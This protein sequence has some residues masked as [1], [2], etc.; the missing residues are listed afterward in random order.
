[1]GSL[2]YKKS[3]DVVR[4]VPKDLWSIPI[5]DINMNDITLDKFRANNKAFLFVNVACS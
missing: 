2:I 4:N 1:M 3:Y 5:K